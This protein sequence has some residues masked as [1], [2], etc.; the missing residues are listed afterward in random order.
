[1]LTYKHINVIETLPFRVLFILLRKHAVF[2]LQSSIN[3]FIGRASASLVET[4]TEVV[5]QEGV[6]NWID[7]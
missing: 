4:F 1:M 7:G 2:Q 5:T 6:Q 3:V